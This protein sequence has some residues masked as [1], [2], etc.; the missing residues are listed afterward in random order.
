MPNLSPGDAASDACLAFAR[1]LSAAGADTQLWSVDI[2]AERR[3]AARPFDERALRRR[4]PDLVLFHYATGSD[5]ATRLRRASFPYGLYFHNVTPPRYFL[6][7][8]DLLAGIVWRGTAD[9]AALARG[10]RLALAPS[11]FSADQLGAAGARSVDV[12]PLPFD[13]AEHALAPD[14]AVLRQLDDG[15]TNLLFVG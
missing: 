6:G 12:V 7:A 10:A 15:R 13:P 14:P 3:G 9:L 5:V 8:N 2:D 11:R 1:L 4:A